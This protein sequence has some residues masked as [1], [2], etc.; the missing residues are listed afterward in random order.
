MTSDYKA[1]AERLAAALDS[2]KW[3]D[4]I[5]FF[6]EALE[7]VAKRERELGRKEGRVAGLREAAEVAWKGDARHSFREIS[8]RVE[9]V[10]RS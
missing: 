1:E 2:C 9:E 6:A 4:Y 5:A 3:D 10:E 7:A 8:R